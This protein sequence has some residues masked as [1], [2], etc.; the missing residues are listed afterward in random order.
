MKIWTFIRADRPGSGL[1][2]LGANA[3]R[4]RADEPEFELVL[5]GTI[6]S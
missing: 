2:G 6:L 3:G 4:L 5:L 1:D